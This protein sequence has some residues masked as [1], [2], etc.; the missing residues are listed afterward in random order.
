MV[1]SAA[2]APPKDISSPSLAKVDV[3]ALSIAG[4]S[5]PRHRL[6]RLPYLL[7]VQGAPGLSL[8]LS[9]TNHTHHPPTHALETYRLY[10]DDAL[11]PLIPLLSLSVSAALSMTCLF[12]ALS[13][14]H[15]DTSIP[16]MAWLFSSRRR[17]GL[18]LS[19][20]D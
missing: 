8:S 12:F 17:D 10:D 1:T 18:P 7:L 20:S 6:L 9:R 14:S 11:S 13:L 2:S 19:S 4:V 5:S 15:Y 16:Y 3:A